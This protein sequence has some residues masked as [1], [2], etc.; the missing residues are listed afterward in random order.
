MGGRLT[1]YMGRKGDWK[2]KWRNKFFRV[3]KYSCMKGRGYANF[4]GS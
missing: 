4:A 1:T 2:E 3:G